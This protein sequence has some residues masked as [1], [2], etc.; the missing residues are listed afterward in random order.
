MKNKQAYYAALMIIITI[1]VLF[2]TNRGSAET[3]TLKIYDAFDTYSE[4]TIPKSGKSAEILLE[5]SDYLHGLDAKLSPYNAE[6]EISRL[7]EA[8]GVSAVQLSPEV[9]DILDKSMKYS[10]E[11]NGF[12]D[13]TIG[14]L[15]NL[16][17]FGTDNPKVPAPEEL[18]DAIHK[19]GYSFLQLDKASGT[20]MLTKEGVSIDLGA[21]AKGYAADELIEILKKHKINSSLI[22]LGGNIYSLGALADG[23]P[24][25]IGIQDP[26]DSAKLIGSI[27]A[28]NLAVITSGDYIRYFEQ[29]GTRYHHILNP[30]TG[31]PANS[32]IKS[33]TIISDNAT[34]AD[35]LSTACFVIGYENSLPLL[36]EFGAEAIFVTNTEVLY[37]SGIA[38]RFKHDN[39]SYEYKAV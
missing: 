6:S 13:I 29:D 23:T 25:S 18:S 12:F 17:G 16:W 21:I 30:Y 10:L 5:M 3:E 11:T 4:I 1:F 33:V 8:A 7:N 36:K 34:L 39:S 20:A 31:A 27:E 26:A 15:Y 19:T 22:N 32:G 38:E 35:A 28:S 24:R 9:L 2:I 14:A 37:T